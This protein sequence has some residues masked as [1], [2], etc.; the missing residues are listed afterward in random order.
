M[1]A[2]YTILPPQKG[3]VMYKIRILSVTKITLKAAGLSNVKLPETGFSVVLNLDKPQN[4]L[5]KD[6]KIRKA[7]EATAKG[8]YKQYLLQTAKRLQQFEKLFAGMLKKGAAPEVVAKQA[9]ALKLTLEKETPDWE[10]AAARE[11][12]AQLKKLAEKK[13]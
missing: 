5:I 11:V 6:A 2:A 10:K 4:A 12:M 7:L 3:L 9:E 8:S 13:R 1:I